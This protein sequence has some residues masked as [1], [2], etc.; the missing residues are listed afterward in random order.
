MKTPKYVKDRERWARYLQAKKEGVTLAQ[1]IENE[2]EQ[3]N[4]ERRPTN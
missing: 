3:Q 4:D 1:F 2:K